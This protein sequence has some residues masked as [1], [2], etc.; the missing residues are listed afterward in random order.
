[1]AEMTKRERIMTALRNEQPDR[2]PVAPDTSYMI[3]CKMTGKPFY[4]VLLRYNPPLWKAYLDVVDYFDFDGWFMYGALQWKYE[5]N[6]EVSHRYYETKDEHGCLM[7]VHEI[8]TPKGT[9]REKTV[10]PD[11]DCD[12]I[13]EKLIKNFKEDF[14]KYK[15][16]LPKVIGYD[17]TVYQEQKKALGEKGM[18]GIGVYPPG[19]QSFIS[20]SN[21]HTTLPDGFFQTRIS[22]LPSKLFSTATSAPP[23]A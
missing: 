11:A 20:I 2:I 23:W 13:V 3:P 5:G 7:V 9:L 14:P 8:D 16:L 10:Y 15:Y 22:S 1:M 12:T 4:E 17:D 18:M 6:S 21:S 19:F